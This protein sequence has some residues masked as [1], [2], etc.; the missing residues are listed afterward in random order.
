[1]SPIMTEMHP[2]FTLA[3]RFRQFDHF[4][5]APLLIARSAGLNSG[6]FKFDLRWNG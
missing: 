1:M 3:V 4:I 6:L 5:T 2:F